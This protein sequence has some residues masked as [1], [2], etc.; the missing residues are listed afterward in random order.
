SLCR[1]SSQSSAGGRRMSCRESENAVPP[2]S[3]RGFLAAAAAAAAPLPAAAPSVEPRRFGLGMVTYNIAAKWDLATMLKICRDV[4]IE[5]VAFRT[6]HAH[7]VEPTLTMDERATVR[8]K[9]TDAGVKVWGCGTVCEF[10]SPDRATVEK[11]I[12]D[13]KR[14]VQLAADLGGRGV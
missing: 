4:K 5:A 10:H 9:C 11:N 12:E 7:G 1:S 8:K 3:R 2:L 6:T 14:F 13:C